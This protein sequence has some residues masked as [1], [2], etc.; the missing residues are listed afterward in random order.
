MSRRSFL[1]G[2][3]L[4]TLTGCAGSDFVSVP[5]AVAEQQYPP[6]GKLIDVNG[7]QVHATDSETDGPPVVLIHG[8]NVNLRDWTFSIA[9]PLSA[10]NRVIA[11]DRPGY[12]HSMRGSGVWT[13]AQSGRPLTRRNQGD[14]RRE[15]DCGRA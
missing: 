6:L 13:P 15:T 8:S 12:G 3:G 11:V 1:I 2:A 14:G 7:L 5:D 10:N 4:T 9:E